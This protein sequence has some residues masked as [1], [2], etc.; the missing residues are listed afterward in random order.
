MA[1]WWGD[2]VLGWAPAATHL[3][4]FLMQFAAAAL[5]FLPHCPQIVWRVVS[6]STSMLIIPIHLCSHCT[7]L[8]RWPQ[9][10]DAGHNYP[11]PGV[12]GSL[13]FL[14]LVSRIW[15]LVSGVWSLVTVTD[16]HFRVVPT[17]LRANQKLSSSSH[18]RMSSF[19]KLWVTLAP[20]QT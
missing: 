1:G 7:P 11:L 14:N 13:T 3:F 17:P 2:A 9:S 16:T 15:Y 10:L 4:A 18:R 12:S 20:S 6:I 19:I 8:P 5:L